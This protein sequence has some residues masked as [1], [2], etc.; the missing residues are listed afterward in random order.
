MYQTILD[1]LG[2]VQISRDEP[3]AAQMKARATAGR[4][5]TLLNRF[6]GNE[7]GRNEDVDA[8]SPQAKAQGADKATTQHPT[9]VVPY[10]NAY[11]HA[12]AFYRWVE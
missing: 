9:T 8:E 1:S 4:H 6:A 2:A 7:G 12:V 3:R 10:G 5:L 11:R